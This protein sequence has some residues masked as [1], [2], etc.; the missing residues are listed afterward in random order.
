MRWLERVGSTTSPPVIC[1]RVVQVWSGRVV[2]SEPDWQPPTWL[3]GIAASA[4]RP[5][6]IAVLLTIA[7][8]VPS[9]SR[10][11]PAGPWAGKCPASTVATTL[12][13]RLVGA[14]LPIEA[15]ATPTLRTAS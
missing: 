5:R 7:S 9:D 2:E 3:G 10:D 15:A 12:L 14:V 6:S 8:S 13:R 4:E 1:L 11:V